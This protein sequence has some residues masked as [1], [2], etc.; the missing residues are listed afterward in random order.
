MML[1]VFDPSYKGRRL[2]KHDGLDA[3]TARELRA[4]YRALGYP[5]HSIVVTTDSKHAAKTAA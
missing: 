5:A 1:I 3:V 2:A 4:V